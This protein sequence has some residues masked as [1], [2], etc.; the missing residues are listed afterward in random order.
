MSHSAT[1]IIICFRS[2]PLPQ[3]TLSYRDH[4]QLSETHSATNITLSYS[5]GFK[6]NPQG[7]DSLS[8]R[9]HAQPSETLLATY[10][11]H[12]QLQVSHSA[13]D[14]LSY[15]ILS[16]TAITLS[17]RCHAQLQEPHST[18]GVP[19]PLYASPL[20]DVPQRNTGVA[21]NYSFY[22]QLQVSTPSYM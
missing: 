9:C 22:T 18:R 4:T 7:Q 5:W 10:R 6:S 8:Y 13:S 1:D 2:N 15:K 11:C 20:V 12:P 14:I 16:A 3:V 19:L 21:P 17:F